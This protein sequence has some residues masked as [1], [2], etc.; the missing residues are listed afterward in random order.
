MYGT[1]AEP[2]SLHATDGALEA[3]DNKP[4]VFANVSHK[5]GIYHARIP[6]L[7]KLPLAAIAII[8]TLILVNAVV[9]AAVGIILV[10]ANIS[11]H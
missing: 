8:L 9:W 7:R 2:Q 4:S 6:Y 5:A 1:M 3:G 10:G 11:I